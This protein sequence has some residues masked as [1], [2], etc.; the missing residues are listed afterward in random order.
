[1]AH[2]GV[3]STLV[4]LSCGMLELLAASSTDDGVQVNRARRSGG[5]SCALGQQMSWEV[6]T[7]CEREERALAHAPSLPRECFSRSSVATDFGLKTDSYLGFAT[8]TPQLSIGDDAALPGQVVCNRQSL[9]NDKSTSDGG[10]EERS[11]VFIDNAR[12]IA[13]E[14]VGRG[15][16]S[17]TSY[18]ITPTTRRSSMSR[19]LRTSAATTRRSI[20]ASA[21][22]P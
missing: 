19:M 9:G 13:H 8:P 3:L 6:P 12:D 21:H 2:D 18:M 10:T 17:M 5:A 16:V 20:C 7:R 22:R 11:P 4:S 15:R 14:H 1:M